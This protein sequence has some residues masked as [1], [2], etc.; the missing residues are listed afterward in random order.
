MCSKPNQSTLDAYVARRT[1]NVKPPEPVLARPEL[2]D[3]DSE[4]KNPMPAIRSY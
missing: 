3:D 4:R 1:G 2:L